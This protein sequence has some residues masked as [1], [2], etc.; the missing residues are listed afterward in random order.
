MS[1]ALVVF[2]GGQDS[3]TCLGW[4]KNRFEYVESITFDYGQKH[5]VEIAQA[6]KIANILG[7]KNTLLSLDAFSQLND[8]A[9][10]DSTQDIGAHHRTHTNLPASFVPNR[11][12][13]FF[14]L[15]HAFAQKQGIN[16]I[17]IGVNQTDYSGYPDCREPF[18]KALELALNLGSEANITFHYPLMH[19]TKAETFELSDK[20][21]V[22]ELVL[23]ESHT[24]YNGNH[25]EKHAW[26]YGCGECPACILRKAGW[27]TY[28]RDR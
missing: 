9:L 15:A 21:G 23:N 20:E 11:N 1:R 26:G 7:I 19:L 10:I 22:L 14:T 27:E 18:V 4:A 13:I 17:I 2:S 8:S 28:E 12:A 6:E 16:H 3:T 25:E 24:C 5:R